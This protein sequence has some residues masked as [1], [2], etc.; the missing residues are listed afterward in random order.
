MPDQGPSKGT[1]RDR[2][3]GMRK[4]PSRSELALWDLLRGRQVRGAKFRRQHPIDRYIAD[5]ACVDTK[6]IVEVDGLSHDIAEQVWYDDE[7]TRRLA[8]LGWRVL[9]VRDQEVLSDP[10]D[11]VAT[12][13]AALMAHR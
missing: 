11:V 10:H 1:L 12:I 5:F 4:Q 13:A 3:R 6:L 9:R 8:E 2:A 7:R